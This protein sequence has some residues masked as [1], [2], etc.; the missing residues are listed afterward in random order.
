MQPT[1]RRRSFIVWVALAF[2]FLATIAAVIVI[3]WYLST[4]GSPH[5]TAN[6]TNSYADRGSPY[7]PV[8]PG[9]SYVRE[10]R[11]IFD[12]F[13]SNDISQWGSVVFGGTPREDISSTDLSGNGVAYRKRDVESVV[14]MD[15]ARLHS[16]GI[17][18]AFASNDLSNW[19][20]VVFGGTSRT[21]VQSTDLTGNGVA[22]KE[23]DVESASLQRRG[24]FS[25]FSENNLGIWSSIVFGGKDRSAASSTDETGTGIAGTKVRREEGSLEERGLIDTFAGNVASF[26]DPSALFSNERYE[27]GSTDSTVNGIAK[28]PGFKIAQGEG[29]HCVK[30]C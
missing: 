15:F 11:G 24:I 23:R 2:L 25:A 9:N 27:Y 17:F 20:S 30:G 14:P 28:T 4:H 13:G 7:S 1:Q 8:P 18:D 21:D 6:S 12:A 19:G 29:G 3:A 26:T 5:P 22:N 16:R 10:K